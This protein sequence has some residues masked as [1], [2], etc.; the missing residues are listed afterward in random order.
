MQRKADQT[1]EDRRHQDYYRE[2]IRPKW[3]Q[4]PTM[5]K[6]VQSPATR[7]SHNAERYQTTLNILCDDTVA[8]KTCTIWS[9]R[10]TIAEIIIVQERKEA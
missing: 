1:V 9:Y 7:S 2:P 5:G 8:V 10:K 4:C 6:E 3:H